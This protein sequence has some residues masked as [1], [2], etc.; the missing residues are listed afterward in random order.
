MTYKSSVTVLSI[1]SSSAK[2]GMLVN[3]LTF[4]R[5]CQSI[6]LEHVLDYKAWIVNRLR[7]TTTAG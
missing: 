1:I 5:I 3:N 7:V 6:Y 4:I 2:G